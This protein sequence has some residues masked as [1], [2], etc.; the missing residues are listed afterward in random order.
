[1][2]IFIG[3]ERRTIKKK[4]RMATTLNNN[5]VIQ[6]LYMIFY[7]F[8]FVFSLSANSMD[9]RA[10]E[11][12]VSN[13]ICCYTKIKLNDNNNDIKKT[14]AKKF[15]WRKKSLKHYLHNWSSWKEWARADREGE[16]DACDNKH[17]RWTISRI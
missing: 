12:I 7:C 13:K 11:K 6:F 15:F 4:L 17:G 16:R 10:K 5:E 8:F 3:T 9:E 1:M 2:N 14:A